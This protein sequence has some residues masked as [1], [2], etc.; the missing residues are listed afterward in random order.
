MGRSSI[1]S[2]IDKVES[3]ANKLGL[4]FFDS[5]RTHFLDRLAL[6]SIIKY[7]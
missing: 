3:Y 7:T 4:D 2:R 6:I 5:V 1:S